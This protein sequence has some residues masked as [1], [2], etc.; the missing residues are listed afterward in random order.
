M[1]LIFDFAMQISPRNEKKLAGKEINTRKNKQAIVASDE[2]FLPSF[3]LAIYS[4]NIRVQTEIY[5]IKT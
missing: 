1:R 5:A 3:H 2:F 4:I